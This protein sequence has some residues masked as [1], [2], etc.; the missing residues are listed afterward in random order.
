MTGRTYAEP[1]TLDE[2]LR[3]L[4]ELGPGAGVVAGGTDLVVGARSGKKPLPDALVAIHRL[5]EL[6]SVAGG[7]S[8]PLRLG[9]L[10]T[11]GSIEA[12]PLL[13]ERYSALAEASALVGSPATRHVGT[14][15]GNLCNASPAMEVGSPL[16]VYGASVELTS[17]SGSRTL[18][19]E[20]FLLGPGQSAR[21]DGELLTGVSVPV[22]PERSGSA[23]VRLEYRRAMEIAVVGAAALVVLDAD[24]RCAEAR[25]ALTAVA[26]TCLRAAAAE[27]SLAGSEPTAEALVEAARLSADAASPI[28]DVRAPA[29]Y[30]RAMVPVIVRRALENA[31][32][33]ARGEER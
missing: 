29:D 14:L 17:V 4:G 6:D 1:A 27:A 15:G 24:G 26:P 11:H 28:D 18:A 25:I 31:L 9:A 3:V 33:R 32:A 7:S 8:E 19:V 5:A 20:D 30:R 10:V 12:S 22:L 2:A 16:L 21:A 13:R 23:Y